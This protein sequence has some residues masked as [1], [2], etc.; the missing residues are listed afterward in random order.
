MTGKILMKMNPTINKPTLRSHTHFQAPQADTQTEACKRVCLP[1]AE[2]KKLKISFPSK[3]FKNAIAQSDTL[4]LGQLVANLNIDNGCVTRTTRTP[5]CNSTYKKLA[6]LCLSE[7]LC[8]LSSSVVA[9]SFVLR[10]RQLSRPEI[11]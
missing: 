10:N 6:V 1:N 3:N 5:A 7:V 11:S 4:A 2:K 9:D 8:F